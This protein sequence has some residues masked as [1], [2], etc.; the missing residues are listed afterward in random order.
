MNWEFNY[1]KDHNYLEVI[2]HGNPSSDQL[3]QMAKERWNMLQELNCKKVL[4]DFTRITSMLATVAIYHRPEE[5]ESIGVRRVNYT[6]AVVPTT[7]WSDF[8]FMETVYQNRGYDLH[9]FQSKEDALNYL[10][11]APVPESKS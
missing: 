10:I 3:N 2:V 5:T 1:F 11:A 9:V 8:K 7:Y 4:F 6:A